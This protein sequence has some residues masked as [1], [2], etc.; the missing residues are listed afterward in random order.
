MVQ[1][2]EM[3]VEEKNLKLYKKPRKIHCSEP[4]CK[5]TLILQPHQEIIVNCLKFILLS[6]FCYYCLFLHSA[7]KEPFS[8]PAIQ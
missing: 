1:E 6:Y 2:R 7:F 3:R 4:G 8:L 5:L